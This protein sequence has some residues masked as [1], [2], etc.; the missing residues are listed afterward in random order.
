MTSD[1]STITS[2]KHSN[3][4]FSVLFSV[5]FSTSAW[6]LPTSQSS[7]PFGISL[8]LW[9]LLWMIVSLRNSRCELMRLQLAILSFSS[10][11]IISRSLSVVL[12]LNCKTCSQCP[13]PILNPLGCFLCFFRGFI[14]LPGYRGASVSESIF[15]LVFLF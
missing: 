11:S 4:L 2:L 8:I 1:N 13:I 15:S 10:L 12:N 7:S 14:H 6:F 5:L 3:P 9:C